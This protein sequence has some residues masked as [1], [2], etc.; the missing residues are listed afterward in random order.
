MRRHVL[1]GLR[2]TPHLPQPARES[3]GISN[4]FTRASPSKPSAPPCSL[5]LHFFSF[6]RK[7]QEP[8]HVPHR[9]PKSLG[10][11]PPPP[12]SP[13]PRLRHFPSYL[14]DRFLLLTVRSLG[15]N[16]KISPPPLPSAE[17]PPPRPPAKNSG[18]APPEPNSS[19]P[20]SPPPLR[21]APQ[22]SAP[23]SIGAPGGNRRIPGRH[24][25]R[26]AP[27]S[28]PPSTT[29]FPTSSSPYIYSNRA[30]HS[31]IHLEPVAEGAVYELVIEE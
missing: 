5:P 15:G 25:S 24:C 18:S 22:A 29:P 21:I 19:R 14:P 4:A 23:F 16:Q 28:T 8:S 27:S 10:R 11:A 30:L 13:R 20:P 2:P 26:A 6:H 12:N 3:S 9:R 1:A 7:S 17:A 31:C